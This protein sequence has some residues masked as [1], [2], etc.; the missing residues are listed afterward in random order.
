MQVDERLAL[1]ILAEIDK[2]QGVWAAIR[3][4]GCTPYEVSSYVVLFAEAGLVDAIGIGT[5]D[6]FEWHP[7]GLTGLGQEFLVA[8]RQPGVL[9]QAL[10][11]VRRASGDLT[12]G[13]LRDTVLHLARDKPFRSDVR[14]IHEAAVSVGAPTA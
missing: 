7:V 2:H 10:D 8:S 3:I 11:E 1:R 12:I 14:G 13:A 6:S 9:E 4:P 5:F